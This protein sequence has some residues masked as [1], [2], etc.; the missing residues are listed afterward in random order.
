MHGRLKIIGI[1]FLLSGGVAQAQDSPE[2]D[3]KN[4]QTQLDMNLCADAA[5]EKADAA[6][7][8]EYKLVRAAAKSWDA[9]LD[10]ADKGA[11]KALIAAQRAWIAYPDTECALEGFS[12]AG[13]SMQPMIISGCVERL[14]TART[15]ELK[16]IRGS[17]GE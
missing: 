1:L 12:A 11:E 7:N 15:S 9:N 6:L 5:A 4:P 2:P 17:F 8:A 16:T 10:A 3:C 13:G 14:T